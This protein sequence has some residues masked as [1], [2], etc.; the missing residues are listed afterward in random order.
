[1]T[2]QLQQ[3]KKVKSFVNL[4]YKEIMLVTVAVAIH[5]MKMFLAPV[6]SKHEPLLHREHIGLFLT[7]YFRNNI[8]NI[9][10]CVN[11]CV[12][13]RGS[14]AALTVTGFSLISYSE[15]LSFSC[16]IPINFKG[17]ISVSQFRQEKK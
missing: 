12:A 11:N 14:Q 1:M 3:K 16:D 10:V 17:Y 9:D 6:K 7:H 15:I 5:K 4:D 2:V 8:L 13:W